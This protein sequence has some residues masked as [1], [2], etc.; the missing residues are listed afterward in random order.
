MA[1]VKLDFEKHE[2]AVE[3]LRGKSKVKVQILRSIRGVKYNDDKPD[4]EPEVESLRGFREHILPVIPASQ[5]F[6]Q[7]LESMSSSPCPRDDITFHQSKGVVAS[8]AIK[9]GNSKPK[10]R[11]VSDKEFASGSKASTPAEK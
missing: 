8:W 4:A 9:I 5:I 1:E 2:D 11:F 6:L 7:P 10:I 3:Y